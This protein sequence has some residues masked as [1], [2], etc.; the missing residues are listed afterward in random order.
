MVHFVGY[1][2]ATRRGEIDGGPIGHDDLCLKV[3]HMRA[4]LGNFIRQ[5]QIV[6]Q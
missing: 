4:Q 1:C 6:L 3:R 2:L 5:G